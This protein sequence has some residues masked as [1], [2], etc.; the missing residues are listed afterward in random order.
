[1]E[2]KDQRRKAH[3]DDYDCVCGILD[4]HA[5]AISCVP[6]EMQRCIS[7]AACVSVACRLDPQRCVLSVQTNDL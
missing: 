1:M 2:Y 4:Y 5:I 6:D 7:D 3:Q